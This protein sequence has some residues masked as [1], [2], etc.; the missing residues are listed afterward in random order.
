MAGLGERLGGLIRRSPFI[1]AVVTF[2]PLLILWSVGHNAFDA[3]SNRVWA[4]WLALAFIA[5]AIISLFVLVPR[6][7]RIGPDKLAFI[8][9]A[10]AYSPFL[11]GLCGVAL[12]AAE[13]VFAV[14]L[15]GS[16]FLLIVS[17][18]AIAAHP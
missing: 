5:Y 4:N 7:T 17:A 13:W 8:R 15:I 2:V 11:Y 1:A 12:G 3:Q 10:I 14:G 9:W 16:A 6:M 18:R